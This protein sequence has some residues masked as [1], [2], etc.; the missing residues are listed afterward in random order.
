MRF[1]SI[2]GIHVL[3]CCVGAWETETEVRDE[4]RALTYASRI[5]LHK[6]RRVY[7]VLR[8]YQQPHLD[9][10]LYELGRDYDLRAAKH[11]FTHKVYQT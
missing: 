3:V 11:N 10:E 4:N 9:P 6:Q 2:F 8:H 5:F 7:D 1:L